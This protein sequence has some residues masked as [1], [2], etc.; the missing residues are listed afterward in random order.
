MAK[1]ES[2]L[3]TLAPLPL[4]CHISMLKLNDPC[5]QQPHPAYAGPAD[6]CGLIQVGDILAKIDGHDVTNKS[7]LLCRSMIAGSE[8]SLV[9]FE[10]WRKLPESCTQTFSVTLR[11]ATIDLTSKIPLA[12]SRLEQGSP[13]PDHVGRMPS[14]FE[15]VAAHEAAASG[16]PRQPQIDA[17]SRLD[18]SDHFLVQDVIH[19][20]INAE[21]L[22]LAEESPPEPEHTAPPLQVEGNARTHTHKGRAF[23]RQ[24]SDTLLTR[25]TTRMHA[26]AHAHARTHT[27]TNTHAHTR[28]HTHTHTH[29]HIHKHKHMN[30]QTHLERCKT[31]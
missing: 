22:V 15:D 16:E 14:A 12:S 25:T 18:A 17:D 29:T 13:S 6:L 24:I 11:R 3:C 7:M 20:D 23:R 19:A 31:F 5:V 26:H 27:H 1:V 28:T 4:M 10:F 21:L 8:G 9:S 2:C 30:T